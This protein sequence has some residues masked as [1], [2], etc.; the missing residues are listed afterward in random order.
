MWKITANCFYQRNCIHL[1][2]VPI[3][4][5]AFQFGF[6]IVQDADPYSE[7]SIPSYE[8]TELDSAVSSFELSSAALSFSNKV[9]PQLD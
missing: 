5:F 2:P 7:M 6:W 9:I 3:I 4:R 1:K 8:C